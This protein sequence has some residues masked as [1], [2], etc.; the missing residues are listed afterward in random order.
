MESLLEEPL[1]KYLLPLGG[2]SHLVILDLPG[3]LSHHKDSP[4]LMAH[5]QVYLPEIESF[6]KTKGFLD[7]ASLTCILGRPVFS[8]VGASDSFY[9]TSEREAGIYVEMTS[10]E[11][12]ALLRNWK[13]H[14]DPQTYGDLQCYAL[15]PSSGYV[16]FDLPIGEWRIGVLSDKL[17]AISDSIYQII[18]SGS[19][20]LI[21]TVKKVASEL[22][23]PV[24]LL[25]PS[26]NKIAI[27]PDQGDWFIP[28]EYTHL[29]DLA[30]L[31]N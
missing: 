31:Y 23:S 25:G 2:T 16:T 24:F 8:Y 11:I 20:D 3:M 17:D 26:K 19:C 10:E 21:K 5:E 7:L 27:I 30:S 6:L 15:L 22:E 18:T 4:I 29:M 1:E 28:I 14:E 9:F 12:L 13:G